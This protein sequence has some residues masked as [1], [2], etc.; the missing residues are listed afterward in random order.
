MC[1]YGRDGGEGI[2]VGLRVVGEAL[3]QPAREQREQ[4][5]DHRDEQHPARGYNTRLHLQGLGGESATP[6]KDTVD[7]RKEIEGIEGNLGI[8]AL[9]ATEVG[10]GGNL[11]KAEEESEDIALG[12][13]DHGTNA[14]HPADEGQGMV[15]H[16]AKSDD[17]DC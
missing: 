11:C 5:Q 2:E 8:E 4:E 13:Q 15:G 12:T 17:L 10:V 1:E 3:E 7:H 6:D 16:E 14:Q 9:D